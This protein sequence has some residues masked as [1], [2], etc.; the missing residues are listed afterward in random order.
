M[1]SASP[2]RVT[3]AEHE[4]PPRWT[5]PAAVIEV[6]ALSAEQARIQAIRD[7]HVQQAV[8]PLR[9]L[10]RLSWPH[11]SAEPAPRRTCL[12]ERLAV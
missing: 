5:I 6:Y 1:S 2:F 9:S 4:I 3:I 10:R 8:P 7:A 11:V 12:D